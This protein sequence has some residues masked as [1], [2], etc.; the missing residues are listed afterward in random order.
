[1][2]IKLIA[3]DL[4]GTLMGPDFCFSAPTLDVLRRARERDITITLATGRGSPSARHFA[5]RLG[6]TVPIISYQ[7]AQIGRAGSLPLYAATFPP[8]F[9]P[10]VIAYCHEGGWELAV[11]CAD[12]IYQTTLMYE[13]AYYERWFGLPIHHVPDLLAALPGEPTK[14]IA[15]APTKA[16]G[17]RL[18]RELKIIAGGQF[19]ALRSHPWFVEGLPTHV[20]KGNSLARLAQ[21]LGIAQEQ[22]MAIGDS[23]N[24][25]SMIRWA[26]L[27]VAMGNAS[28]GVKMAADVIAPSQERDG[29]A[30]AIARY[31]LEET[32]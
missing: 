27:G 32:P 16:S 12:E 18:E 10:R 22:T 8:A 15:I 3:C 21:Y 17:D 26:G 25:T 4:D 7:G 31:A 13:R 28:P 14:F 1:M 24:D 2:D 6:I 5:R 30:W 19:Q 20:S 11:Y 29:A 23:D 9:L